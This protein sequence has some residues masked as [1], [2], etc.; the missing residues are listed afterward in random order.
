MKSNLMWF[1][2]LCLLAVTSCRSGRPAPGPLVLA[3]PQAT[4]YPHVFALT[5]NEGA[6]TV[7]YTPYKT[8]L[9]YRKRSTAQ[10]S[11]EQLAKVQDE[12][13]GGILDMEWTRATTKLVNS[14]NF[15]V[16]VYSPGGRERERFVPNGPPVRK[17][18]EEYTYGVRM[19]YD[20]TITKHLTKRVRDGSRVEI[21]DHATGQHFWFLLR[22]P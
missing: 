7:V 12:P 8:W 11:E 15:T 10:R 14:S 3:T 5:K 19:P 2:L 21:V 22:L 4:I 13:V 20:Q 18:P 16:V 17:H 9:T 6:M 1:H